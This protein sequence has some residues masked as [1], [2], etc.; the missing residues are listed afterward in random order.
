MSD[1]TV[2]ASDAERN[3]VAQ[4]LRQHW[5]DGRLEFEELEHR[6]GAALSAERLKD[7]DS[8]TRDLPRGQSATRRSLWRH[9]W[10]GSLRF[11]E[12]RHLRTHC[13]TSFDE[14][15][16]EMVPRMAMYDFV[17]TEE[18]V[19][20]RLGF[21]RSGEERV[22]VLFHPAE[23][24]GTDISAFGMAPGAIRRAFATLSD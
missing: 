5:L 13:R 8:V 9:W 4:E 20:R 24:G 15:L 14:A 23:D 22:T 11:H 1:E 16:R 2:R 7:L 6:V 17:L 21:A 19:P 12:V 3:R 10:P 18:I